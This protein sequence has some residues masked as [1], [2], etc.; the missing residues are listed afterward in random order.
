MNVQE[1]WDDGVTGKGIVVTILD[2]GLEKDHPD[3]VRNY[4]SFMTEY[5]SICTVVI[6]FKFSCRH[7]CGGGQCTVQQLAIL[8]AHI[9]CRL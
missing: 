7:H 6:Q 1:A 8:E 2:D 5:V 3:I 9:C 4:V